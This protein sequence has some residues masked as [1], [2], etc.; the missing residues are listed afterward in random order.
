MGAGHEQVIVADAR[1]VLILHRA[2]IDG[3]KLAEHVGIANL[4]ARR[5]AAVL[6]VLGIIAD[7]GELVD[8]VALADSSRAFNNHVRPDPGSGPNLHIRADDGKGPNVDIRRQLGARIHQ[9]VRINHRHR[10]ALHYRYRGQASSLPMRPPARPRAP[11][12]TVARYP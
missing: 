8:A 11:R 1:G 2:A 12:S 3:A 9:R 5:L 6:L 7:R 10:S 4:K